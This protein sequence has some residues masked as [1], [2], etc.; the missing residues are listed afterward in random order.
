MGASASAREQAV[1]VLVSGARRQA[2]RLADSTMRECESEEQKIRWVD[3]IEEWN[4]GR[5]S[6]RERLTKK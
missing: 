4:G 2:G 3:G 5:A 6:R 1:F